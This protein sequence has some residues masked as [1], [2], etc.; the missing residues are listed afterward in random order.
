VSNNT[1]KDQ[2]EVMPAFWWL[3]NM[4][5]LARNSSKFV[6][7]DKRKRK[8]QHIEFEYLAPDTAEEI[9]KAMRLL[10]I[11]T[12]KASLRKSGSATDGVNEAELVRMG[13]ELLSSKDGAGTLEV[14]GENIEKSKRKVV[15]AKPQE[16]YQ[17]YG[18]MLH[19]YA[20]KSLMGKGPLAGM[21]AA[22]KDGQREWA[23]LGGQLVP[24]KDADKLR[25][26]IGTGRLPT[27]A[28]I[29]ARYDE[30]WKSYPLERQKHAW[31]VLCLLLGTQEPT[32]EQW[33][34]CLDKAV[35]IQEEVCER[36]AA[37]KK[38]DFDEAFRAITYRNRQEM[39]AAA[40]TIEG[41][42]FIEQ[43]RK[44][45]R[46]FRQAAEEAKKTA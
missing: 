20:V 11:W 29:H 38:K 21:R 7:R 39:A 13:K 46:D 3:Y 6:Q 15:I 40:G 30:L 31:T 35:E 5:A 10:E 24:T 16:A 4:Y 27:W 25:S 43:V 37:S 23:N 34:G 14:L 2:L 45:A 19:Y 26:D 42:S 22:L 12:A 8:L 17:A 28:N 1:S 18:R 32:K 33:L 41:N 44:E 36:V 9:L